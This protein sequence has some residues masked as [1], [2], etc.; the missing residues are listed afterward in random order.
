[1]GVDIRSL[2][3]F[4]GIVSILQVVVLLAQYRMRK[5]RS[6]PGLWT[7]GSAFW[8]LG[9]ICAYLRETP[10]LGPA[11][12]VATNASMVS[13]LALLHAGVLR[14]L[15]RS[16]PVRRL[17]V[18]CAI[19]TAIAL[20]FKYFDDDILARR[21]NFGLAVAAMSWVIARSLLK[22]RTPQVSTSAVFLAVVF[23]ACGAFFVLYAVMAVNGAV[24]GGNFT[25]SPALAAVH[26]VALVVSTLCTYGFIFLVNQDM[27]A[28]S[29]DARNS[30][31]LIFNT[32]PDSFL[33][34]TVADAR[35][36]AVND[37]FTELTGHLRDA[38]IGKTIPEIGIWDDPQAYQAAY[39]Q[40][41]TTGYCE[42]AEAVFRRKNG[43][44][45]TGL[46]SANIIALLGL[47]HIVSIT[48]DITGRREVEEALRSK[49]AL[50]SGI[51]EGTTDAVFVKD[52]H[53]RYLLVNAAMEAYLG[54][55]A[56]EFLGRDDTQLF[57]ADEARAVMEHDRQ[58][59]EQDGVETREETITLAG[60]RLAVFQSTKGP[61]HDAH[62]AVV[63]MFCM[64]RDMTDFKQAEKALRLA[65]QQAEAANLAKSEFLA[66]MSHEI[67]TP[68]NGVSGMLQLLQ[69]T[70]LSSEQEEYARGA[71]LSTQR[72]TQL[73]S[74]ILDLSKVESGKLLFHEVEFLL[75]DVRTSV[76]DL[77]SRNAR[78][79]G[80][81]LGVSLD[82]RL[83]RRLVGD[84][85]RLRQILFNVVGNALK[86]TD[87]GFVRVEAS[88]V[89][90]RPGA[91]LAIAFTVT[92]TGCG[93]AQDMLTRV[94]EPFTQG[95]KTYIRSCGGVGLGLAIVKRLT[96]MMAGD[97]EVTS[98]EG[99]GTVIR[100]TLPFKTPQA[101]RLQSEEQTPDPGGRSLSILLVEDDQINRFTV[102]RILEK[103]GHRVEFAETGRSVLERLAAR[104]FDCVIMD[105][106]MPDMDGV[107]ATRVIRESA[108]LGHKSRIPIIAMTAYAMA[109][110]R[111]K[112]LEAGMDDYIAKPVDIETLLKILAQIQGS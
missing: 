24:H 88:R 11:A 94:F 52:N 71:M 21:V 97:I 6:G 47:P 89:P 112:F 92:D 108:D 4:Q 96:D 32:V 54:R 13:G 76:L 72:L 81:E 61:L 7:L 57:S 19:I 51:I 101:V 68:L 107:E 50:L 2:I 91:P 46:L 3:V 83:P 84:D 45:F 48:R 79:K 55:P 106:Q 9:F 69:M 93:I 74:D 35:I 43:R 70:S 103:S 102:Q 34:S 110:D 14:F 111:E 56:W 1:M 99:S 73:L 64:S 18:F 27:Q 78:D 38:V 65:K 36:V 20:Y 39:G 87:R 29:D 31:E 63:G 75:E 41:K 44:T 10:G 15:G 30:L 22:Y 100:V 33:I 98:T 67:R 8:V 90:A 82:S 26:A 85:A 95:D 49:E 37:G 77:F 28:E 62:G 59:M 104:D 86:F 16:V 17:A 12:I 23:L 5:G 42:N 80:L 53:G 40:V 58:V 66:N 109:G 60:G 25:F 105:I